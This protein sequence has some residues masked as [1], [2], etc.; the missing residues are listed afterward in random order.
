MHGITRERSITQAVA[1]GWFATAFSINAAGSERCPISWLR[2]NREVPQATVDLYDSAA[3]LKPKWTI[4]RARLPALCAEAEDHFRYRIRFL[5]T[6]YWVASS[7]FTKIDD[8]SQW[9]PS[10]KQTAPAAGT[11]SYA[12][13]AGYAFTAGYD[14]ST[15][16]CQPVASSYATLPTAGAM[17]ASAGSGTAATG[18]LIGAVVG[19]AIGTATGSSSVRP[20]AGCGPGYT[21][22][23]GGCYSAR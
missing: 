13:P 3:A 17:G 9:Q 23:N 19:G 16:V 7:Q 11:F 10:P 20:A 8:P 2:T 5:N 14:F 22:Y 6:V 1:I 21:L 18:A 4:E 15:G 12:C